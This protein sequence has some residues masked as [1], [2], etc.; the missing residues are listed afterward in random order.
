MPKP[1]L[2][3]GCRLPALRCGEAFHPVVAMPSQGESLSGLRLSCLPQP[4]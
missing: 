4:A 1:R 2:A 3:V